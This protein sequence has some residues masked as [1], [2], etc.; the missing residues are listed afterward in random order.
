[1]QPTPA[2]RAAIPPIGKVLEAVARQLEKLG[3]LLSVYGSAG[4]ELLAGASGGE[5]CRRFCSGDGICRK[6]RD[7]VIKQVWADGKPR[8]VTELPGCQVLA[9]PVLHRRRIVAV[10]LACYLPTNVAASEEFARACDRLHLDR[11]YLASQVLAGVTHPA[12]EAPHWME[13]IRLFL[14]QAMENAVSRNELTSFS[15]SLG[16]TYEELS[17]LYR[18]SGAMNVNTQPAE[19]FE[20]VCAEMLDVMHVG[21]AV[22][23]LSE[24][25]APDGT[26]RVIRVGQLDVQDIQLEAL[27][28][29]MLDEGIGEQDDHGVVVNE[30]PEAFQRNYS[31][32]KNFVATPLTAG[33]M[34]MG[35]LMA[36]NKLD[37][38][39][40]STDLKLI[41][42]VGVQAAVFLANN[43]LY[44]EL[45][46]LLMGVL[47]VLT[48]S[49]DAKDQYTCGHSQRVA[50]ISRRL[51]ELCS[52]D[53]RRVENIYLAGLL[54]DIGKI[55]I[56]ENVLCKPGKLS[57]KE[58]D[59]MKSHSRIGAN[60]LSNIRQMKPVLPA[61]LH[62][63]ERLDGCGYPDGLAGNQVPMEGRIVGLADCLDAMTS[64]RTYRM[65]LPL[66]YVVAEIIRCSGTQFDPMLVD[67]LLTLDLPSFLV[68]LR[69]AKPMVSDISGIARTCQVRADRSR[70]DCVAG[71]NDAGTGLVG[72]VP[73]LTMQQEDT[74]GDQG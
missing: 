29:G 33:E 53:R 35:L 38:E 62:H 69:E 1:M 58:F 37:G 42:S 49:I 40:D 25:L 16:S 6:V 52:F 61:V 12:E 57:E 54:H 55:G 14:A 36:V 47:H 64:S 51:A 26:H 19:F 73:A 48:A 21:A 5:V 17:L 3:L 67:H 41:H 65:A 11:D 46:E 59:I 72:A 34:S 23:V 2:T 68:E 56:P 28:Q 4:E 24:E 27:A 70:G 15:N 9:I 22:T 44:D 39:F 66:E 30:M 7:D 71:A 45:Q 13:M 31:Q 8:I 50:L 10:A 32:I 43:H 63:H 74:D 18:L 20:K 60:I